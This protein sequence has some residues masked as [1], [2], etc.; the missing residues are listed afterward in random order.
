MVHILDFDPFL[1]SFVASF[2]ESP[3]L[4][5]LVCKRFRHVIK[6]LKSRT[7]YQYKIP[8][9]ILSSGNIKL[10]QCLLGSAD[11]VYSGD[12]NKLVPYCHVDFLNLWKDKIVFSSNLMSI[13]ALH[14]NLENMKWLKSNGC[15]WNH[16]TFQ[17]AAKN[18]NLENMTSR[19]LKDQVVERKWMP[20]G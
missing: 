14:G 13:V 17:S 10:F 8:K 6:I 3:E 9:E 16:L 2:L 1:L 7:N 4:L 20:L 18:G 11:G 5:V 12:V 19:G 15:P